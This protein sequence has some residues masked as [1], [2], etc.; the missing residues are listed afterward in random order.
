MNGKKSEQR[1][2]CL[3]KKKEEGNW[4]GNSISRVTDALVRC[5]AEKS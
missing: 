5:V 4:K 3:K 1:R 2:Q